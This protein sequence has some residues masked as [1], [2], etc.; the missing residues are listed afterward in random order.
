MKTWQAWGLVLVLVGLSSAVRFHRVM[1]SDNFSRA[2]DTGLYWTESAMQYRHAKMA[3][4]LGDF[5]DVD[6]KAE[7]PAGLMLKKH[8]TVFMEAAMGW[9]YRLAVP[10]RVPFHVFLTLFVCVMSSLSALAVFG[11]ARRLWGGAWAGLLAAFFYL[12][13]LSAAASALTHEVLKEDFTLTFFF[14]HLYFLWRAWEDDDPV[15][16]FASG[17]FLYAAMA[18]WH[19]TQFVFFVEMVLAALLAIIGS[20]DRGLARALLPMVGVMA[21]GGLTLPTL[22][23]QGFLMS[24]PFMSGLAAW[25]AA[26]WGARGGSRAARGFIWMAP[27]FAAAVWGRLHNVEYSHVYHLIAA[28]IRW[29]N[30]MPDDP[31]KL[32]WETAVMWTSSFVRADWR[33]TW[34]FMGPLLLAGSAG[35]VW[36]LFHFKSW[37]AREKSFALLTVAFGALYILISRMDCFIVF[38]AAVYAGGLAAPAFL[39]LKVSYEAPPVKKKGGQPPSPPWSPRWRNIAVLSAALVLAGMNVLGFSQRLSTGAAPPGLLLDL[40]KTVRRELPPQAVVLTDF[41]LGPSILAFTDRAIVLHSKFETKGIR[42]NIRLFEEGLF[43]DEESFWNYCRKNKASHFIYSTSMLLGTDHESIR[44]RVNR[45]GPVQDTLAYTFHFAPEN[46]RRFR[47]A[48]ANP[49]YEIF[50]VL[51]E[52]AVAPPIKRPYFRSYDPRYFDEFNPNPPAPAPN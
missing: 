50:E 11:L 27:L 42:E 5:P 28:K 13:N 1:S 24:M 47:L 52:G 8:I 45:V 6:L 12:F 23:A 2:D 10:R 16:G 4:A 15:S 32:G 48:W 33:G 43:K 37:T 21:F 30:E 3:A 44:W 17:A 36:R 38:S 41:P 35:F 29:L 26:A 46:L 22:R 51:P 19:M 14:A 40:L 18:S 25:A 49:I 39:A 34:K 7:F 20:P 31:A 9:A